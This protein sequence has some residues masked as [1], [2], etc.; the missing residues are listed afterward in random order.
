MQLVN[1]RKKFTG[2]PN[3]FGRVAVLCG[4][5]S[6][7]REISMRSGEAVCRALKS[8]GVKA[9]VFDFTA[10]NLSRFIIA[11]YDRAFIAL[12]GV[13]GEDGQAQAILNY[14]KIP[15]TGSDHASSALGMNKRKTKIIWNQF[16]LPTPKFFRLTESSNWQE[17]IDELSGEAFVKPVTEGSSIGMSV[18]KSAD[19]LKA[20]FNLASEYCDD[21]IAE[22]RIIGDEYTVSILNGKA[23]P[24]IQI[25]V[26]SQFYDYK[27]KYQSND[28]QYLIPEG[29]SNLKTQQL[30]ALAEQAF[31]VIGCSGWGRIDLM[32]NKS[33]QPYLLEVNT[34]PG[35]TDHSLVPMSANRA[36]LNF[37]ELVLEI[38]MQT[39][40]PSN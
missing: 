38:L 13:G 12:H 37:D 16:G 36:G 2:D 4:G 27:A 14:L 28:T 19:E 23:L 20:A 26:G 40:K 11:K 31:D 10:S 6:A 32:L 30:N 7:E 35:M 33:G 22:Q 17:V 1:F 34:S 15:F 5:E 29:L 25:K 21:V 9:E 39:V 8:A 24:I 3:V 18:A